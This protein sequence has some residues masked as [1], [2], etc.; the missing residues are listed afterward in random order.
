MCIENLIFY[1]FKFPIYLLEIFGVG[2][3]IYGV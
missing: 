1:C 2:V 3:E